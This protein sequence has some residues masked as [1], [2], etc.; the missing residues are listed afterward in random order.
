VQR[1]PGPGNPDAVTDARPTPTFVHGL[2]LTQ[3]AL[4]YARSLH[5]GQERESDHAAFILHPLEVASLLSNRGCPDHV[6][7]AGLLHDVVENTSAS[8]ADLRD[9]FGAP[10]ADLVA[11]ATEDPSIDEATARKAE[12]RARIAGAGED[13]ALLFA[14]DKV[15]KVRELRARLAARSA[16]PEREDAE[17]RAKLEHYE[18]SLEMLEEKLPDHPLVRQ[19]RFELEALH[20]FPPRGG[21]DG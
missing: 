10:V 8:V 19:L 7:A 15:C 9:R 1:P 11:A 13:A 12:L 4:E 5:R 16:G 20:F 17:L 3:R 6:V 2:P 21:L 18:R 14:A